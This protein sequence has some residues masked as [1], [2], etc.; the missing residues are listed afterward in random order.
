MKKALQITLLVDG[1][2]FVVWVIY[3]DFFKS[4]RPPYYYDLRLAFVVIFFIVA[5]IYGRFYNA[6]SK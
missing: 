5:L 3:T 1:L 4:T 2:L 6:G